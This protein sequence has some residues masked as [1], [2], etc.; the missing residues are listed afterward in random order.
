MLKSC[1]RT[2]RASLGAL[3]KSKTRKGILG[4]STVEAR[5]TIR[6]ARIRH[7]QR[8]H[9]PPLS[10]RNGG[11]FRTDALEQGGVILALR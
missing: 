3:R 11:V 10:V 5:A 9:E 4:E 7:S 8:G 1:A 6:L 2:G